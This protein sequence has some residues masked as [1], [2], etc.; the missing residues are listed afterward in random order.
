[1]LTRL[2]RSS[3]MRGSKLSHLLCAGFVRWRRASLKRRAP[4]S[5]SALVKMRRMR[6]QVVF[7]FNYLVSFE[8]GKMLTTSSFR[9]TESIPILHQLCRH[10]THGT[11]SHLF[12][13]SNT[14]TN[15][16]EIRIHW[17]G[18]AALDFDL[19]PP[20]PVFP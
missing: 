9:T 11:C 15:T 3:R 16:K 5:S 14:N 20:S 10:H 7:L 4:S 1:M 6:M 13:S 17:F 12:H 18:S 19:Y 2:T 8:E